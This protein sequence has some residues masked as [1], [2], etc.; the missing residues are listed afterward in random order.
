MTATKLS[1]VD[2]EGGRDAEQAD[3][4]ACDGRA[5]DAGAVEHRGIQRDGIAHVAR[6]DHLVGER[7]AGRHV[8]GV[9]AAEQDREQHDVPDLHEIRGRQEGQD[10]REHHHHDL[11]REEGLPL[12]QD[13][14]EDAGEQAQDHDRQ[15]LRGGHD[16]QPQRDRR[17]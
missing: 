11:G 16:T 4:Q 1:G 14:G 3:R 12:G 13:V 5:D 17:R 7:L 15:E 8:D 2:R 6:A 9:G 10:R